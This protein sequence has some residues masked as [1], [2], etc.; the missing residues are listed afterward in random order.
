MDGMNLNGMNRRDFAGML[1][2]LLAIAG[3]FAGKAEGQAAGM[4]A[5]AGQSEEWNGQ[6][7]GELRKKYEI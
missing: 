6:K 3:T 7:Q 2:G 5:G 1:A 4:A